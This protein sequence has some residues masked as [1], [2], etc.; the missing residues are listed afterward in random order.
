MIEIDASEVSGLVARLASVPARAVP[1]IEAVTHKAANNIKT[2]LAAD[3][4]SSGH[5]KYF[6]GSITY[7]R[8]FSS[9]VAIEYE[10]GPDKDRRQGAL[11]NILYFGTSRNGPQ[12]DFEAPI[13]A[14]EPRFLTALREAAGETVER[15]L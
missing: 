11:G 3:A 9:P 12:L 10:V 6:A 14:E 15:A 5:Y 13:R 4:Q 8:T 7:D 1:A 2:G